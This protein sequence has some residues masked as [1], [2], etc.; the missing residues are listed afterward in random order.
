MKK[1]IALYLVIITVSALVAALP[2]LAVSAFAE[3]YP[4][5]T[6]TVGDGAYALTHYMV[7][8]T[9]GEDNS[10]HIIEHITAHFNE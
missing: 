2:R 5:G 7:D 3:D 10:F 4:E 1:K 8:I 9:V 6:D